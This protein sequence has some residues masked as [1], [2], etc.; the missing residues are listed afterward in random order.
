MSLVEDAEDLEAF[1]NRVREPD[2]LFED[3]IKE[4]KRSGKI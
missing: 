1:E 3:V 4:L 2:L